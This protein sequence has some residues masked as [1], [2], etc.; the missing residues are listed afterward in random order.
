MYITSFVYQ[1]HPTCRPAQISVG[2]SERIAKGS[3]T[4]SDGFAFDYF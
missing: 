1:L 2:G 3:Q 4:F